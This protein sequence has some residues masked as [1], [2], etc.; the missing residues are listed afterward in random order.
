MTEEEKKEKENAGLEEQEKGREARDAG[1]SHPWESELGS[2]PL[3]EPGEDPGWAVRT[4]QIWLWIALASGAFILALIV[5][6][7]FYD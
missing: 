3:R 5:L 1:P 4:V 6:G 2:Y 7:F